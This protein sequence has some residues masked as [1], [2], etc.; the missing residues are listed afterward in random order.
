MSDELVLSDCVQAPAITAA[1]IAISVVRDVAELPD[2]TSPEDW[3]EA[4]IVTD[5]EIL[6][7]VADR[8]APALAQRDEWLS[9][10]NSAADQEASRYLAEIKRLEEKV[11]TYAF[12]QDIV[13]RFDQSGAQNWCGWVVPYGDGQLEVTMQVV[14]GK[15]TTERISELTAQL[16]A[17]EAPIPVVIHC[18]KCHLQHV[19]VD[20]ETGLWA[21]ARH[22]KKHLCKPEDGGCGYV[23]AP[24]NRYTVGV[25]Q[26]PEVQA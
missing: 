19:D 21:T 6:R 2:R 18:P 5:A 23:W 1:E 14:N 25:H 13:N 24:A 16:A 3:P 10:T 11:A 26:L 4:M 9:N 8:V 17:A 22:H 12:A 7:I 15:S 20:E